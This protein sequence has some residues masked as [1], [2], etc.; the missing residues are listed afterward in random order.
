MWMV[1]KGWISVTNIWTVA[2]SYMIIRMVW[3]VP[4]SIMW[5]RRDQNCNTRRYKKHQDFR[6]AC[7][8]QILNRLEYG[9]IQLITFIRKI[10]KVQM[11]LT[12]MQHRYDF[13][14]ALYI[15]LMQGVPRYWIQCN[16]YKGI[17]VG[18]QIHSTN[19]DI[20]LRINHIDLIIITILFFRF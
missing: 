20:Y 6:H 1:T 5:T 9:L 8:M 16:P 12:I 2:P 7:P 14:T 18:L 11:V 10:S 17:Y 4:P 19:H 15:L 3:T 13:C